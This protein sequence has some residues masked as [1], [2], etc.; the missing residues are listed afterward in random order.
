MRTGSVPREVAVCSPCSLDLRHDITEYESN[1][2][3]LPPTASQFL[4]HFF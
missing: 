2:D 3:A 1:S 4:S